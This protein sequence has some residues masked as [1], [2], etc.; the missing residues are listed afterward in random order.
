MRVSE[1]GVSL[2]YGTPD[3]QAPSGT[4]P[5]GADTSVTIGLAPPDA[6]AKITVLYRI[7]HGRPLTVAA[8]PTPP[9]VGKQYFRAVLTGFKE[10][11]KV[12]YVAIYRSGTRQIPS[13]QE[14]ESH[15]VTFI[16]P[17]SGTQSGSTAGAAHPT[18]A[19]NVSPAA[20]PATGATAGKGSYKISGYV[21]YD[22]GLPA[23]GVSTRLYTK[24][25]GGVSNKLG[26]ITTDV[27][28]YYSI[29]YDVKSRQA[30]LELRATDRAGKEVPL[31]ETKQAAVHVEFVNFVAPASLHPVDPEFSRISAD[32]AR[33]I[34]SLSKLTECREDEHQ[35][36]LTL[37][38]DATQW[39]ARLI[40]LVSSAVTIAA[41][42]KLATDL[43]YALLRAGLPADT[44]HLAR[45]QLTQFDELLAAAVQSDIVR[46]S[47]QQQA[48]AATVFRRFALNTLLSDSSPGAVSSYQEMLS[49]SGLSPAQQEAFA[50]LYFACGSDP[51]DLW[52]KAAA[53]GIPREKIDYLKLQ[54][55]LFQLTLNNAKLAETLQYEV[56]SLANL[57]RLVDADLHQ[58]EAWKSRLLKLAGN[59]DNALA[60][61]IPTSYG[62][63]SI[64]DR[65]EAYA[66]DLARRVRMSYPTHVSARLLESGKLSIP[67]QAPEDATLLAKLLKGAADLGYQM[68]ETPVERFF[69]ERARDLAAVA[70]GADLQRAK[71]HLKHLHR[72]HQITPSDESLKALLETGLNSAN[73]VARMKFDSFMARYGKKFPDGEAELVYRKSQQVTSI[74]F[75]FSAMA[76]SAAQSSG[77]YAISTP[78]A[79]RQASQ[80]KLTAQYP[81]M[82]ALFG[83]LDFCQCDECRSVLGPAAYLVDLLQF[84]DKPEAEWRHILEEWKANHFQADYPFRSLEDMR[85]HAARHSTGRRS[86]ARQEAP[87]PYE[88]LIARRPDLPHLQLT[89]ENT[90]TVMPYIDIVN[91]IMEYFVVHDSLSAHSG[92]DTGAAISQDLLAEPQ[93]MLPRAYE[94]L[95]HAR[96]PLSLPFD[97]WHS[98][99][100]RLLRHAGSNLAELLDTFRP[101]T[102]LYPPAPGGN[103]YGYSAVFLET[104][105]LSPAAASV[106]TETAATQWHTLYGYDHEAEAARELASAKTLARRLDI[107]YV[108][109][110]AIIQ[111]GFVNPVALDLGLLWTLNIDLAT[112]AAYEGQSA[113]AEE[114]VAFETSLLRAAEAQGAKA[115]DVHAWLSQLRQ[116]GAIQRLTILAPPADGSCE[117]GKTVVRLAGGSAADA[118]L[119][120]RINLF[121]RLKRLLGWST[122]DL[123]RALRALLPQANQPVSTTN[124]AG[125]FQT[126]LLYLSHMYT[127]QHRLGHDIAKLLCLWGNIDTFGPRS[128]Y[129]QLFLTSSV[130]QKD[131]VFRDPFGNYLQDP[132]V[133]LADHLGAIQAAIGLG[134]LD[135]Q[136]CLADA[137]KD[138]ATAVLS[139]N[140]VSLLHRYAT[141]AHA[142]HLGIADFIALKA[143]S[144][145][146]PFTPLNPTPIQR[147]ADDHPYNQTIQFVDIAHQVRESGLTPDSLNYLLRH[148]FDPVGKY[149]FNALLWLGFVKALGAGLRAIQAAQAPPAD[150]SGFTDEVLQQKIALVVPEDA[151]AMFM[152]L[153]TGSIKQSVSVPGVQP[154]AQLNPATYAAFP[155]L[156]LRYDP[157]TQAQGLTYLGAL[158]D[159]QATALLSANSAPL[160]AT[161]IGKVQAGQQAF[162]DRALSPFLTPA[163]FQLMLAPAATRTAALGAKLF[164]YVVKRL[165]WQFITTLLSTSLGADPGMVGAFA[166]QPTLLNDPMQPDTALAATL[167]AVA[168]NALDVSTPS[169][170]AQRVQG[171]FEVPATGPYRFYAQGVNG[172]A[173][174]LTIGDMPSPL[175]QGSAA[176][177]SGEVSFAVTLKASTLYPILV[178]A[179]NGGGGGITLLVQG[180]SLPKD[181]LAQLNLYS[182]AALDG[183]L[184]AYTLL[185]KSFLVINTLSLT[186]REI[187]YLL[188]QN[189]PPDGG[190]MSLSQLPVAPT[191]LTSQGAT[192]L[193]QQFLNL[194]RYLR[195]RTPIAG[196]G[197]DLID[198]FEHALRPLPLPSTGTAA[199]AVIPDLVD[200]LVSRLATLTRRQP[201]TVRDAMTCLGMTVSSTPDGLQTVTPLRSAPGLATLWH[202]L[203]LVEKFGQSPQAVARWAV[204][205]PGA[206]TV[207]EIRGAIKSRYD[208]ADWSTIAPAIFDRLRQM[209]RDALAA[210]IMHRNGFQSRDKLFEYFL[211]DPGM[212]PIVQTSR[213]R[214]A[215]SSLQTFIQRCLLN[216][217]P[218][219]QPTVLD[220]EQW[221]W[222]KRYRVWQAN[223]EIF[224]HPE[225]YMEMEFRD[226]KTD[227]FQTLEGALLQGDITDDLASNALFTYLQGL[228]K[229]SR[230][231]I[232][233]LCAEENPADPDMRTLHVIGRNNLQPHGYFYRRYADGMWTPWEAIS[234]TISGDHVVAAMF[235]NRLNLFWLSFIHQAKV[236]GSSDS[237]SD[238]DEDGNE[239]KLADTKLSSMRKSSNTGQPPKIVQVQLNWA[240][241]YQGK[242]SAPVTSDGADGS[243]DSGGDD[244]GDG[245]SSN[246]VGNPISVTVHPNF[247][248]SSVAIHAYAD[249]SRDPQAACVSVTFPEVQYL[250][251]YA[252]PTDRKHG[253]KSRPRLQ[254]RAAAAYRPKTYTFRIISK[255]AAPAV[256]GGEPQDPPP[257]PG[258]R[259]ATS[260]FLGT[261]ALQVQ[262]VESIV[263]VNDGAPQVHH[264]RQDVVT[265]TEAHHQLTVLGT[266]LQGE[267]P[268]I[269]TLVSPFFYADG[270][271][272]FFVEPS[273]TETTTNTWEHWAVPVPRADGHGGVPTI[274]AAFPRYRVPAILPK[275]VKPFDGVF[276]PACLYRLRVATDT[277]TRPNAVMHFGGSTVGAEGATGASKPRTALT[278]KPA[279]AARKAVRK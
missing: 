137:G 63:D 94:V 70:K 13:N 86:H 39:D 245:A 125:A 191:D 85:E 164:P 5:K 65:L 48:A 60:A 109:L 253:K 274:V 21:F 212:E 105:G 104:I 141:L 6:A 192:A 33:E 106:F 140:N 178:D 8:T 37:L 36:D 271:S 101:L 20:P 2:W 153:W 120:L 182:K 28:G 14:A 215:M 155:Q 62:A 161:L 233:T 95:Q 10:N 119:F 203:Q 58:P 103:S 84:I 179:T 234:M 150:P 250:P 146:D 115:A 112:F 279:A 83:S 27:N 139:L 136:L 156:V 228:E 121:V 223:R 249:L 111:T 30:N 132:T 257:F 172:A 100:R 11:D 236:D 263:H 277:I 158:T 256:Q 246:S 214:L 196:G 269:G 128:L 162:F 176:L 278:S 44:K 23:T 19:A 262:Y 181:S 126:G 272:S 204:P 89:C 42:S 240:E 259:A 67:G 7:N 80:R 208:T 34:G 217:E 255:F 231:E 222:M 251:H 92:Y 18:T 248:P 43:V 93:N 168:A 55:C 127:L 235:K 145:L 209:K 198:F 68:G 221:Q 32:I 264:A 195:L 96:Y 108:E 200:D 149:R 266:P 207:E 218:E 159:T 186:E 56:G 9:S 24:G 73:A 205:T 91:E 265:P 238:S 51:S 25:F 190:G 71:Q 225:N 88:V 50:E 185:Q 197:D 165:S 232:V 133:L 49:K 219:V 216:L 261:G 87:T 166:T 31:C 12:E 98:T 99:A 134:A 3:A 66:A 90:N 241:Y 107:S 81:T 252:H 53:Q 170:G 59:S 144:G 116:G 230:L 224:L 239:P 147:L 174:S 151:A 4:L 211:V 154:A 57:A 110:N 199:P 163:D 267:V 227:L 167:S 275:G 46:M 210:F 138:P 79:Q 1:G 16:G 273:L 130:A 160:F 201:A 258:I 35:R 157:V 40:G 180:E 41:E 194:A 206:Q 97:L 75:G 15:V 74:T 38:A 124:A 122:G 243:D 175:F 152:G 173:I 183:A 188:V 142:L 247:D 47:A 213:L 244:S 226:D 72:M 78:P 82:E 242:W 254:V 268:E 113:T 61:L 184:R 143:L 22:Y 26:E 102:D 148:Q 45:V 187:R 177:Q 260:H 77:G 189:A 17:P 114:R 229:I 135:V 276:D 171:F 76:K 69:V 202:L 118:G 270:Q 220:S 131:A 237:G 54:G 123:D 29:A 129:A 193:F 52:K 64:R 117:F 169:A